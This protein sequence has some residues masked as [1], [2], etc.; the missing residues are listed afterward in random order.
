MNEKNA[1]PFSLVTWF[2]ERRTSKIVEYFNQHISKVIDTCNEFHHT[3]IVLTREE[4]SQPLPSPETTDEKPNEEAMPSSPAD[5]SELEISKYDE[6]EAAFKRVLVHERA[7]DLVKQ[8]LFKDISRLKLDSK[9]REDLFKLIYQ[10]DPIANWVK[11]AAKNALLLLEL[12]LELP[13]DIWVRFRTISEMVVAS[14]RLLRKMIEVLGIDDQKLLDIRVEIET[15]E[16]SVDDLYFIVKKTILGSDLSPKVIMIAL[17]LL[18]GLE[19]ASD[20]AAGAADIL[21]ILVMAS[22]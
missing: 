18:A 22:R 12:Q 2:R 21:Y 19:N 1:E 11:V 4:S 5:D 13:D 15:L 14:S 9:V 7:A 10:I 8:Q 16:Q 17:D 20:H 3:L 6:A